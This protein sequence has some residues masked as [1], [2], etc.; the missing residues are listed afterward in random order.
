MARSAHEKAVTEAE[1]TGELLKSLIGK[2]GTRQHP[3]GRILTAYRVARRALASGDA[4]LAVVAEVLN[5]LRIRVE[6]IAQDTL[7]QAATGGVRQAERQ[8]G[9]YSL[10]AGL[11]AY[12]PVNELT[13]WMAAFDAQ[14]AAILSTVASSGDMAAVLGDG[15]RVGLLSPAPIVRDGSKWMALAALTGLTTAT[16]AAVD[17]A[18]AQEEFGKQAVSA[19]DE[20]TTDCCLRVNGQVVPM[21]DR[22]VLTGYPRWA[23]EMSGPPFHWYCRTATALV[24]MVDADD[25]LSKAM[26]EAGRAELRARGVDDN[27]AVIHPASSRSRR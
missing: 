12:T 2:L 6:A 7:W 9:L 22:F 21:Q 20:R 11:D 10:P 26:R 24:R 8:I 15:T 25:V 4:D 19:I 3:R 17:R 5:E 27:R 14:R 16:W 18:Q 23:D 13:A 1:R